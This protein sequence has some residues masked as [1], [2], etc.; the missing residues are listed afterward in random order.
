VTDG[1]VNS[2][3]DGCGR[4]G[5]GGLG[6]CGKEEHQDRRGERKAAP[7]HA[8][9]LSGDV[10]RVEVKGG[11]FT[12]GACAWGKAMGDGGGGGGGAHR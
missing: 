1:L 8:T 6:A 4:G 11:Q 10:E 3:S 9:T 7:P 2:L 12:G 5:G